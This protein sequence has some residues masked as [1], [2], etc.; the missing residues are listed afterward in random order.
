MHLPLPTLALTILL[1]ATLP[2]LTHAQT[3]ITVP[4]HGCTY[5]KETT[6]V[7]NISLSTLTTSLPS[8]NGTQT[9]TTTSTATWRVALFG[10]ACAGSNPNATFPSSVVC[11]ATASE[12]TSARLTLAD[13]GAA[14]YKTVSLFFMAYAQCAASIYA[15]YYQADFALSCVETGEGRSCSPKLGEG[16][17]VAGRVT[18]IIWLPPVRGLP[19][20]P[21]RG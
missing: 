16:E 11:N 7:T 4:V 14:A 20:P 3:P 13:S 21:P 2:T 18:R 5:I 12:P 8:T 10:M 19:P 9:T 15:F 1:L 17:E 6:P